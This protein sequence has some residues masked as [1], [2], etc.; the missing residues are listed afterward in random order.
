MSCHPQSHCLNHFILN[1]SRSVFVDLFSI[2]PGSWN[3]PDPKVSTTGHNLSPPHPLRIEEPIL[4]LL[5]IWYLIESSRNTTFSLSF[6]E[7]ELG[8]DSNQHLWYYV[9][10]SGFSVQHPCAS[11][12]LHDTWSFQSHSSS[13]N[14]PFR[15]NTCSTWINERWFPWYALTHVWQYTWSLVLL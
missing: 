14:S 3:H 12:C 7:H 4:V 1:R 9:A 10:K 2:S 15:I 11:Y 5:R 13:S 8:R 6:L